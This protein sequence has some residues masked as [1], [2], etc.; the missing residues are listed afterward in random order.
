MILT[1]NEMQQ[2]RR[3]IDE[4]AG[5][6]EELLRR[7]GQLIRSGAMDEAV[8]SAFVLLEERLRKAVGQEAMT[9]TALAN[10]AF[11]SKDGPLAKYMG[12][13]QSEREGLRELY[14]GAFKLFRNPTAHGVVGYDSADGKA[15]IGLVNWMLRMLQRV[16]QLPPPDMFPEHVEAALTQIEQKIGP[17]ATGRLRVF[18]GRC[19]REAGLKPG[20]KSKQWIPFK[21]YALYKTDYWEKAKPHAIGVFYLVTGAAYDLGFPLQ[22]YYSNVVGFDSDELIDALGDLGFQAWGK[23][24]E[25]Y[26]DFKLHNSQA[27]FDG[28]FDVIKRTAEELEQTLKA[29]K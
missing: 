26:V 9:G 25:P 22:Y 15:I 7:C 5:L 13:D 29:E 18:L 20:T 8:R 21:R 27:F 14:S 10:Y 11:N 4:Q 2:V 17:G 3:S 16:E 1:D 12:R 23:N 24:Q 28:L 6:D 19:V